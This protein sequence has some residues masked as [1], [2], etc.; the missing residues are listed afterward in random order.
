MPV[1]VIPGLHRAPA[2]DTPHPHQLD[3]SR[4]LLSTRNSSKVV[5]PEFPAW[6]FPKDPQRVLSLTSP[7][8]GALGG[9]DLESQVPRHYFQKGR[10][11]YV[12]REGRVA[13]PAAGGKLNNVH[14]CC[15]EPEQGWP[16]G[17]AGGGLDWQLVARP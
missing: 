11:K 2:R 15:S 9:A 13:L 3:S 10:D 1:Q 14:F 4:L 7:S 8:Q 16:E 5:I 17:Q 12:Q 6:V